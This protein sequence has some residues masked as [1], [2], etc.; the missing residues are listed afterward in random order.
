MLSVLLAMVLEIGNPFHQERYAER[1]VDNTVYTWSEGKKRFWLRQ[2]VCYE[3][4]WGG[5]RCT[6]YLVVNEDTAW[7]R[8]LLPDGRWQLS[9]HTTSGKVRHVTTH[10]W[11]AAETTKDMEILDRE[12]GP[13][14]VLYGSGF[15][16]L[17]ED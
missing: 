3:K 5:W 15:G 7:D 12:K 13:R 2:F 16:N 1:I 4:C 11:T 10:R 9:F 8:V 14:N 6:G 17:K